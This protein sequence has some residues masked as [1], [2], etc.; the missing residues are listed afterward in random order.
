MARNRGRRCRA[1]VVVQSG[2]LRV[3]SRPSTQR[4][5]AWFPV[6][7]FHLIPVLDLLQGQVVHAREG[8]RA[9][10]EPVQ[11]Q[12]CK[13]AGPDEI[14]DALLRLHPFR[15]LYVADL[16]A[17]Q[18]Q[19]SNRAVLTRLHARLPDIRFWVD[20]GIAETSALERW[21]AAGLGRPVIGSESLVDA[22]FLA[23]ARDRDPGTILSLDFLG[24]EFRGPPAL[25]AHPERYWPQRVLAMNLQRV[26]SRLGPDFELV[27]EL[28]RRVAG[29][30]V[31]A[32]GG[33]R[34]MDDLEQLA[35]AGARGALI[36]SALHDGRIGT[37]ELTRFLKGKSGKGKG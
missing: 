18:H 7:S 9:Q 32:A 24:G 8:R 35:K 29:C 5:L 14:V 4:R 17:I 11:S 10:Y 20:A 26:G 33:V 3:T 22:E 16:D 31:Y 34:F 6:T 12:L 15:T 36:A 28:A 37:A 23:A 13:G 30:Q 27:V 21:I 25:L 19:G 1:A 2:L